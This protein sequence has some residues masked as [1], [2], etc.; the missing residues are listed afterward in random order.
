MVFFFVARWLQHAASGVDAST[1][2]ARRAARTGG[3][4]AVFFF[5]VPSLTL[6][7]RPLPKSHRATSHDVHTTHLLQLVQ[8]GRRRRHGGCEGLC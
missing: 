1:Q 5:V 6:Q 4:G 2:R 8:A 3:S 7:P